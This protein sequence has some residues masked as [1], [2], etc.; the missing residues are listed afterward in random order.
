MGK[1]E[2]LFTEYNEWE[3]DGAG[4]SETQLREGV[5]LKG[6]GYSMVEKGRSK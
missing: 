6:M 2:D 3:F 5:S 4:V 1:M